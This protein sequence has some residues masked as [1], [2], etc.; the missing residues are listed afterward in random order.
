MVFDVVLATVTCNTRGSRRLVEKEQSVRRSHKAQL[1]PVVYQLL[2]DDEKASNTNRNLHIYA[3]KL[4]F[5]L[6]LYLVFFLG[7]R[8]DAKSSF[9]EWNHGDCRQGYVVHDSY[10]TQYQKRQLQGVPPTT[11]AQMSIKSFSRSAMH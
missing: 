3:L 5:L 10:K 8:L 1:L 4:V 11:C 9:P 2:L 6:H 7:Q